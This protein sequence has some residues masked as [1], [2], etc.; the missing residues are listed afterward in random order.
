MVPRLLLLFRHRGDDVDHPFPVGGDAHLRPAVEVELTHRPRLV[1][2]EG[3]G[4]REESSVVFR[5]YRGRTS[6]GEESTGHQDGP[7]CLEVIGDVLV[8]GRG[9]DLEC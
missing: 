5:G 2:L 6:Q 4:E 8:K 1:L 7:L 9:E 3:T